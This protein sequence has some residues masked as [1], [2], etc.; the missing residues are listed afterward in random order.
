M[1]TIVILED[2]NTKYE[3]LQ[4]VNREHYEGNKRNSAVTW[5]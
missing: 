2:N 4:E 1:L 5:R 3:T